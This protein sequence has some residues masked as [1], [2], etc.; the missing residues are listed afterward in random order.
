[1]G[2]VSSCIA[3]HG[4]VVAVNFGQ[5]GGP[6][7]RGC[8][9]TAANGYAL[10]HRAGFTTSGDEHDGAGFICR[11]GNNS[12]DHG[13]QYPTAANQSCTNTP[14]A[15]AYWSY[16]IALPGANTWTYSTL[17]AETDVPKP[18]EV[19]YWT[20]GATNLGGSSGSGVPKIAPAQ[21]RASAT[22]P[23][24]VDAEPTQLAHGSSSALPFIIGICL[25]LVLGG[26]AGWTT[27]HRRQHR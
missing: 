12:F 19:Q 11:L 1:M 21:L 20:F 16:W 3:D 7:V 5:W 23:H 9:H 4:M 26:A 6:A 10:L 27:W 2:D 22:S 14:S 13:T 25:I 15:S 24:V 18:G 8:A 17:G